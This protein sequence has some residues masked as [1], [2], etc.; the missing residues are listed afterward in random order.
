MQNN[1]FGIYFLKKKK[2]KNTHRK[3]HVPSS[4]PSPRE[5][6]LFPP[7]CQVELSN[8]G[9]GLC[10]RCAVIQEVHTSLTA[11]PQSHTDVHRPGLNVPGERTLFNNDDDGFF[12]RGKGELL[13]SSAV[14]LSPFVTRT[15]VNSARAPLSLSLSLARALSSALKLHSLSSQR[16]KL[17]KLTANALIE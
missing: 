10:S 9:E 5:T 16:L 11:P 7:V 1:T 3:V 8:P 17:A 6:T 12:Y 2:K 14:A 15:A 13:V 4:A